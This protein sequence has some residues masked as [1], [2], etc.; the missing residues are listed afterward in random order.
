[1]PE[2]NVHVTVDMARLVDYARELFP[3]P[4]LSELEIQDLARH[5]LEGQRTTHEPE[6][7]EPEEGDRPERRVDD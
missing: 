5:S 6:P 3:H 2:L 4:A 1:M 7:E